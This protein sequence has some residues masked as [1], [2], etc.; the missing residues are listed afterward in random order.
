MAKRHM[1]RIAAPKSWNIEKKKN[2]FITRPYPGSHSFKLGIS[3]NTAFKDLL[4]MA[5]TTKEVKNILNHNNISVNG[6]RRKDPK[7]LVGFMDVIEMPDS[8][9]YFRLLLDTKGR[10]TPVKI[11]KKEAT[12]LILK[13][14]DK[15]RLPK[16]RLQ[17]NFENG[18][19]LI[20]EKDTYKTGDVVVF[21]SEKKKITELLKLEKNAQVFLTGGSHTGKVGAVD[22]IQGDKVTI[23]IK[24]D[25]YET[26]KKYS[27][28]IGKDKPLISL[29]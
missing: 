26:Q 29:L 15:K 24:T 20:V 8:N 14:K 19:N 18:Y 17:I 12:L 23:K 4:S 7:Y 5:N 16:N 6:S 1:K 10:L 25:K 22:D 27:F 3:I 9:E 2:K 13:I 28:V 21:D 11:D